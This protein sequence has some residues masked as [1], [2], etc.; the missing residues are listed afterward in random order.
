MPFRFIILLIALW[1]ATIDIYAQ[2]IAQDRNYTDSMNALIKGAINDTTKAALFNQLSDYWSEKDSGKAAGY[3]RQSLQLSQGNYF[4]IA[5]AHFYLGG[6]Y[7]YYAPARSEKEYL[8]AID[9]LKKD[10]SR[11]ALS[12]QSRAWHNYGALLQ[13]KNDDKAFMRILLDHTIPLAQ[14]AGDVRHEADDYASVA[15]VFSNILDYKKAIDYYRKAIQLAQSLQSPSASLALYYTRL[16]QNYLYEKNYDSARSFIDSA[17]NILQPLPLSFEKASH[18]MVLGMYY[19]RTNQWRSAVSYLDT[20]YLIARKLNLAYLAP[21]ILFQK[22]KAYSRAKM[23]PQAREVLL[24][25]Y[26][27]SFSVSK[28]ENKLMFLYNLAQTDADMGKMES[29]YRW[30]SQYAALA[31]TL[32]DKRLKSDITGLEIKYQSEKKQ[33]EIL[34]LQNKNKQ[35]QLVLQKNHFLNY[36]LL[37]GIFVLLLISLIVFILYRNKKHIAQQAS[38]LHQQ[39]LKE[40][41]QDHQLQVYNAMLEGQEQ[42]RRRM[43]QDLH[44][45]LGGMLAGVKLKLSDIADNHQFKKDMELYKVINQLDNSVQELRRI[46]RNMMPETLIQFGAETALKDLCDS[47]QTPSLHIEFQAY[48]LNKELAQPVQITIYRIVQELL[49]N[50]VKHGHPTNILVQCS[51]NEDRIFITVEDDGKGFDP[52]LLERKKGIGLANIRNRIN[53]LNGKLDIQSKPEEGTIVNVE[54]NAY[55]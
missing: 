52:S 1:S 35:Q 21:S 45:G 6:A 48:Q 15:M 18:Y 10:S 33:R 25:V 53:Y 49:T 34:T 19:D 39:Q 24:K 26:R 22:Y 41:A 43:A 9:L 44:D 55:E 40:M 46:A 11:R 51:Q 14:K 31:D 36:L 12:L 47:L 38:H 29:A 7:F 17:R 28:S 3:A 54:V 50:A 37:I 27:D 16:A 13:R 8:L 30:L 42:E 2:S 4:F 23:Y 5:S 20:A 32:N